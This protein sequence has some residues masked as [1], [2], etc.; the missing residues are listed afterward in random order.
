[1][2]PWSLLI[3][4]DN[5]NNNNNGKHH[6]I[7]SLQRDQ[8]LLGSIQRPMLTKPMC[9]TDVSILKNQRRNVA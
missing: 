4:H 6:N 7:I 5:N 8:N 2:Q 9:L 3:H 1:M